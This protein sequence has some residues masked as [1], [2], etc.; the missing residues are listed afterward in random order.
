MVFQAQTP[1]PSWAFW[2]AMT[3]YALLPVNEEP[4]LKKVDLLLLTHIESAKKRGALSHV[5]LA[6]LFHE[7]LFLKKRRPTLFREQGLP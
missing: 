4:F 7:S 5:K 6:F 2:Q 3:R 1:P